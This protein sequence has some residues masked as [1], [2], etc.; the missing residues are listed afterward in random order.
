MASHSSTRVLCT[1]KCT[2]SLVTSHPK[3]NLWLFDK[4]LA[5]EQSTAATTDQAEVDKQVQ[6]AIDMEDPDVVVDLR[7]RNMGRV[8]QFDTF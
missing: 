4:E 3:Q 5:N 7:E 6:L 8:A 2:K 1:R